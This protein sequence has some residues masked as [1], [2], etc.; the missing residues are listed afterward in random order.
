MV[1]T[2][3]RRDA[4][5]ELVAG[6]EAGGGEAVAL[7]GDVGDDAHARALVELATRRFGGLDIGLLCAGALGAL[8]PIH[9]LTPSAWDEALRVNLTSAFYGAR[10]QLP[11]MFARGGGS[12]TFVGTF[13]GYTAGFPGMA[14][15]AASKAGL[16]GLTQALA[17][18]VGGRGV[19]VN[20]LLPGGTDTP[21]GR[22]VAQTP[23]ARAHV[24]NL[25]ALGR[26]A[27]PEEIAQAALFLASDAA[28]F[29]T[30]AA[31]LVDGGVSIHRP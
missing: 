27:A 15:Y 28:S 22:A 29:V 21:M 17:A 16:V 10:H 7:A 4:L 24:A 11:A 3:R 2:A 8:G 31:T 18:E 14:A 1:V 19:R 13:V 9:T 25:H 30:G 6:F 23:E 5:A 26:L 20:A 12:L